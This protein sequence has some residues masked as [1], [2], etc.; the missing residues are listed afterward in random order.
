MRVGNHCPAGIM[1]HGVTKKFGEPSS[2][3]HNLLIS[4]LADTSAL[5][6]NATSLGQ[7]T[8]A[9]LVGNPT[10]SENDSASGTGS[11]W[12]ENQKMLLIGGVGVLVTGILGFAVMT[13]CCRGK[14]DPKSVKIKSIGFLN[15]KLAF[16]K[17]PS[18][19]PWM[20]L[21]ESLP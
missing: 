18:C 6:G 16:P 12:S 1:L 15:K 17:D 5:N 7:V 3:E 11:K 8:G 4:S 20:L 21:E 13:R 10:F 2:L 9:A 19:L 14:R